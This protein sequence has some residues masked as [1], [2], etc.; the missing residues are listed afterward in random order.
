M[1]IF[2]KKN[3]TI[4]N[5]NLIDYNLYY[6]KSST[7]SKEKADLWLDSVYKDNRYVGKNF[8]EQNI[9]LKQMAT[10]EI[11]KNLFRYSFYHFYTAVRGIFDPGR[12]DLI[13]FFEKENGRQ[14]FLE[15]LNSDKSI[16]SLFKN[17]VAFVYLLLIP[18]FLINC[19]KWFYV[20]KYLIFNKLTLN[21]YYFIVLFA[22]YILVSGPVNCSR[23][24][25]P[26]QGIVI[27][28]AVLGMQY[29]SKSLNQKASK[30]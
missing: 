29:K 7:Q 19:M 3:K 21:M 20:I 13:T 27:V 14:G 25:M 6:F 10:N 5:K 11:K 17:K 4:E 30:C 23:Y 18:I 12:Y 9:Y 15:V 16:W 2:N 26:F 28:F 24:M 1:N 8:A 22:Y